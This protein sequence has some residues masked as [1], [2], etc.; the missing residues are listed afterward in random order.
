MDVPVHSLSLKLSEVSYFIKPLKE[1]MSS[2]TIRII[3]HSKFP[4]LLRHG[5]I[6]FFLGGGGWGGRA[7][8]E[9]TPIFKLQKRIIWIMCGVGTGTS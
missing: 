1:I 4:S 5:I 6:F 9:N 8:N 7:H 2:C 3:Y